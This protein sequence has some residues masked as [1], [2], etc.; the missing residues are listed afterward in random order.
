[1][2]FTINKTPKGVSKV[3]VGKVVQ[4]IL[5]GERRPKEI[6]EIVFL[7]KLEIKKLNQRY[8]KNN[9]PT[10]VLSF[11]GEGKTRFPLIS[12]QTKFLGQIAICW[13]KVMANAKNYS[14]LPQEEL[15]RV[16]VHGILHLLG[17][18]HETDGKKAGRMAKKQEQY[19]FRA[20]NI[21]R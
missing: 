10:D 8:R 6:I 7:T 17:Y 16:I 12:G 14:V 5:V 13:P 2:I 18:D 1:M 15:T 19:V 3:F 21:S 4:T 11:A 20:L 9:H